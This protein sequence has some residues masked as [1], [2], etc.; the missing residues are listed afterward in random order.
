MEEV[1]ELCANWKKLRAELATLMNMVDGKVEHLKSWTEAYDKG[2]IDG[3]K[4]GY[5][6][7][8]IKAWEVSHK[9]NCDMT[10]REVEDAF[11]ISFEDVCELPILLVVNKI[12]EIQKA[13][14]TKIKI[15][16]EVVAENGKAKFFV[17]N[18]MESG[19]VSG[20]DKEGSTYSYFMQELCGKIG[21]S[22]H[23]EKLLTEIGNDDA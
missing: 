21:P 23:I 3:Y 20:I 13:E 4:L 1:N 14:E 5:E 10:I 7:G 17:T 2:R 8:L 11:G 22:D 18:I 16:D 19:C 6:D 15:G 12:E 9:I